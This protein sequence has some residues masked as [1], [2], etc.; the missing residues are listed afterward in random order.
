M[1]QLSNGC[2]HWEWD[3]PTAAHVEGVVN[4]GDY[5]WVEEIVITEDNHVSRTGVLQGNPADTSSVRYIPPEHA[6]RAL[7]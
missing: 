6:R 1:R 5:R 3:I 7:R 4:S 2:C